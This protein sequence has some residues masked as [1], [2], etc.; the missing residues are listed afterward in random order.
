MSLRGCAALRETIF[1]L[2]GGQTV[3]ASGVIHGHRRDSS[4][5][6]I[7]PMLRR[8][9]P[10][11]L[12]FLVALA[13]P[14]HAQGAAPRAAAHA[15]DRISPEEVRGSTATDAFQL[16]QSLR[17]IWLARREA[18]LKTPAAPRARRDVEGL[19]DG[20]H[21]GA[22]EGPSSGEAEEPTGLIVLL[23]TAL[24][25]GRES[26]REIPINQIESVEFLS[27]EQARRRYNRRARDGAIVV[28]TL[29]AGAR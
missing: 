24:L 12:L 19:I 1:P 13:G 15:R 16:V 20:V 18:R 29:G 17:S 23:N 7:I 22:P 9:L 28:H 27:P 3:A 14:A 5:R 6:P 21:A 8:T 25:G 2:G 4:S 11:L 10:L 26:L